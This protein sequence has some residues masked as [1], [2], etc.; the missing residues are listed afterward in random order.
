M[1]IAPVATGVPLS[2]RV[3]EEIRAWMGRRRV[4]GARMARA[5]GVS[6]AWV[7]YR[8]TGVQPIDLND[9]EQ[10]AEVLDVSVVDLLTPAAR[11]VTHAYPSSRR[12]MQPVAGR[13]QVSD[14]AGRRHPIAPPGRPSTDRRPAGGPTGSR[15]H[16]LTPTLAA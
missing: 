11:P 10:I 3:A 16:R 7:S 12:S 5:L 4:T 1:T 9:L 15:T 8:L 6:P 14:T 13:S 2:E